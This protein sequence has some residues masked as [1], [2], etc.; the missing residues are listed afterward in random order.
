MRGVAWSAV[1]RSNATEP[2]FATRHFVQHPSS[3]SAFGR[4]TSS[5]KGRRGAAARSSAGDLRE[6]GDLAGGGADA[7][8]E[9]EAVGAHVGVLI[10]H[11]NRFEE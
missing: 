6:V 10:V 5:R 1:C 4:S 3:V 11:E 9:G 2:H 7:G 8:E